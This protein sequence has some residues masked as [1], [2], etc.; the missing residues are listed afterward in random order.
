MF[1]KPPLLKIDTVLG[2]ATHLDRRDELLPIFL[3]G[4]ENISKPFRFELLLLRGIDLHGPRN[5][6]VSKSEIDP[7]RLIGTSVTFGVLDDG[8]SRP[9]KYVARTGVVSEFHRLGSQNEARDMRGYFAVVVP[10][11]Q[12]LGSET[13]YRVFENKTV[14]DVL[15][16]CLSEMHQRFPD[17]KFDISSIEKLTFPKEFYVQYGESTFGFLSRLMARH[18][19]F[20][21]FGQK[22]GGSAGSDPLVNDTL[23]IGRDR[24]KET[25]LPPDTPFA[26]TDMEILNQGGGP[27][28]TRRDKSVITNFRRIYTP[29]LR[30]VS[31]LDFN[32]LDPTSPIRGKDR[33]IPGYDVVGGGDEQGPGSFLRN[34]NSLAAIALKTKS[35]PASEA[36]PADDY[37]EVLVER[38]E[39][40]ALRVTG[41]TANPFFSAGTLFHVALDQ[42]TADDEPASA[43]DGLNG[44]EFVLEAVH[45]TAAENR[46]KGPTRSVFK[47]LFDFLE[48]VGD[49][50]KRLFNGENVG[51]LLSDTFLSGA[52][53]DSIDNLATQGLSNYL[54]NEAS[55]RVTDVLYPHHPDNW[56]QYT[57][58]W[59]YFFGGILANASG[60]L[61]ALFNPLRMLASILGDAGKVSAAFVAIPFKPGGGFPL[62]PPALGE[63]PRVSGP[64]FA[65][66]IG[67]GGLD[68]AG[69]GDIF[70]DA[71][72]RVRIRF[73][74]DPGPITNEGAAI[75]PLSS[76]LNTCWVRM[77]EGWAGEKFG[78]QFLPRIGQ[79]V[80]VEFVDGDPERPVIT[81]RMYNARLGPANLPFPALGRERQNIDNDYL[82]EPKNPPPDDAM[83]RSGIKTRTTPVPDGKKAG[84]HLLRFDDTGGRE[85]YLIRSQGRL[86][87]TVFN[88]RYETIHRDRNLT[89]GGKK[90]TP[91]PKEIGGDYIGKI[92]R[93][94]YLHVGDPEFPTQSGNRTTR[95]EQNDE[96]FVKK[97][98]KLDAGTYSALT[99]DYYLH[100]AGRPGGGGGK[101][102]TIIDNEDDLQVKQN[103]NQTINGNWTTL[104]NNKVSVMADGA[105][106]LSAF[107]N[108]SLICGSSAI[109]I[110]PT[111]IQIFGP[112][113][114]KQSGGNA[115]DPDV[116][117]PVQANDPSVPDPKDPTNADPGDSLTPPNWQE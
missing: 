54:Q 44:K 80:L 115:V 85:Q 112:V 27:S 21:V 98:Y 56:T 13:R 73:P 45:I 28:E 76:Q 1:D 31:V 41:N 22:S 75:G 90:I 30:N 14:V 40:V 62:R 111:G 15:K 53:A 70:A 35:L 92:Y 89:V 64:H 79:E 117:P 42:T 105:I 61:P 50:F 7:R 3:D 20:Y 23:V 49:F 107:T 86:D 97:E 19:L 8:R 5:D 67:P 37:A 57:P 55:D 81:G 96:L 16:T 33:I 25:G 93:H 65:T 63:K 38:T 104:C 47:P 17:F 99:G 48:G 110:T 39:P 103:L 32:I 88:H 69:V 58:F 101:R 11:F 87:M 68:L 4:Q 102:T 106:A 72:G 66:V 82:L 36:S 78:S 59:G 100:V 108:I 113:I 2:K 71:F 109:V 51:K 26:N 116:P 43:S 77:S 114:E 91:A 84:F 29:G 74:W 9:P 10:A 95:L 34:A 46:Y 24:H 6:E 52:M 18:G 83:R 94:Y 60:V 12:F